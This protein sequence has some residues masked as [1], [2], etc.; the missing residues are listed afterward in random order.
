MQIQH[1]HSQNRQGANTDFVLEKTIFNNIFEKDIRRIFIY[2]KVERLA[3]ALHLITPAF[4]DSPSL[5][6]RFDMSAIALVEAAVHAP[7]VAKMALSRELLTLSS[8]LAVARTSGLLSAMNATIIAEEVQ[9]LLQEIAGYEEPR[10]F[11]DDVPTL[12][13]IAKDVQKRSAL[14][15]TVAPKVQAVAPAKKAVKTPRKIVSFYKGQN[16]PIKD[17]GPTDLKDRQTAILSLIKNKGSVSIK[18]ISTMIRGVSEKTIQ[19]ELAVLVS[20]GTVEKKGERRWSTY[21]LA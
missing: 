10:I 12:A 20:S 14:E 18:D 11:L 15:R 1:A 13:E 9:N 19:R 8:M 5:K 3:K 6:D 21:S 7:A 4:A 17:K 2:K 16:A